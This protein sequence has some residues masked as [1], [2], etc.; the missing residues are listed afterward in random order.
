MEEKEPVCHEFACPAV[1]LSNR[2]LSNASLLHH[3]FKKLQ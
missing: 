2:M 1:R 3:S